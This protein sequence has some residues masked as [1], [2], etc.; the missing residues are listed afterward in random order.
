M[1]VTAKG[2]TLLETLI[3]MAIGSLVAMGA[4]RLL[5]VIQQETLK[6]SAR[7][8]LEEELWQLT[9][10]LAKQL[11]RA[12]YCAGECAGD[13]AGL[14]LA[15]GCVIVQWDEN[16]NGIREPATEQTAWRLNA[17][18]LET[19][20]GVAHCSGKGWEKMNDPAMLS[21]EAFSVT[22]HEQPFGPPLVAVRLAG[23]A[24]RAGVAPVAVTHLITGFN[25]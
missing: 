12:G 8:M 5:A 7:Q 13:T 3:A 2:F 1:S 11:R 19:R 10:T 4:M 25:L 6:T 22:R 18:S 17:G 23:R 24:S 20:R 21:I 14:K 9:F 15:P 16:S